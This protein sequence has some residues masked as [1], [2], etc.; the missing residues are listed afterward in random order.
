[1]YTPKPLI[2]HNSYHEMLLIPDELHISLRNSA[3]VKTRDY[4]V[5]KNKLVIPFDVLNW[6][7][8]QFPQSLNII[9]PHRVFSFIVI[10]LISIYTP[11]SIDPFS[12]CFFTEL[13]HCLLVLH[14]I[15]IRIIGS[16]FL[17]YAL[18]LRMQNR[19]QAPANQPKLSTPILSYITNQPNQSIESWLT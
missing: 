16:H 14:R 17:Q 18:M 2:T 19:I 10:T 1:M 3:L 6:R 4:I 9:E 15:R 11:N 5:A 12:H 7:P 13:L 8:Q